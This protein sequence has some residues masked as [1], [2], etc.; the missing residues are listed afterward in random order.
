MK[1]SGF[2]FLAGLDSIAQAAGRCNRNG[3]RETATVHIVNPRE[4]KIDLLKDIKIGRDKAQRVFDE[5]FKDLLAPEAM[6]QYFY[7]YFFD[8]ERAKEMTYPI[9]KKQLGRDDNL[10]S[11]LSN[12]S[13]N[14]GRNT[15]STLLQQSFMTAGKA[16]KAIDSPTQAV[17]VPYDDEA[18]HLIAELCR[19][20]IEFDVKTYRQLLK[21]AQKYSVNV[22]PNIWKRLQKE[23]AVHEIQPGEAI[24]FLDKQYYSNKF[25]LS[26]KPCSLMESAVF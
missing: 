19:V 6:K 17:I 8:P 18:R 11:L 26:D 20:A 4:E 15:H 22:F 5:G 10:L 23:N 13:K 16:F 2:C 7:Y 9:S 1:N 25:G 14:I 12:N 3:M 24:Y 21:Q